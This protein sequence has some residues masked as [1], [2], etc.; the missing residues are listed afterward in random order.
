STD[1]L[2]IIHVNQFGQKSKQG[3]ITTA[4]LCVTIGEN[5]KDYMEIL[6]NLRIE[7]LC[8]LETYT[9]KIRYY[10]LTQSPFDT[11]LFIDKR[12]YYITI[13]YADDSIF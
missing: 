2:V 5:E 1:H 6:L 11:C 4:I 3:D 7:P 9:K 13:C 8:L 12:S 10:G